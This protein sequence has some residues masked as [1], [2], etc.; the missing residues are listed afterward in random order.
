MRPDFKLCALCAVAVV[1]VLPFA[2][3]VVSILGGN[4]DG[5]SLIQF[6]IVTSLL[7]WLVSLPAVFFGIR[8]LL[9]DDRLPK[10]GPVLCF[11]FAS[12]LMLL[13]VLFVANS[14]LNAWSAS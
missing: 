4:N 2:G 7:A 9:R 14:Y 3:V 13:P 1:G 8:L 11:G 10:I 12:F 5:I 6:A